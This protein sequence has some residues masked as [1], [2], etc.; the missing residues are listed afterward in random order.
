MI[1]KLCLVFVAIMALNVH[2]QEGTLS[3]YSFFGIGTLKFKGTAE[4]RA[5]GGISVYS[6]SIHVNLRNPA[7]YGGENLKLYNQEQR[8]VIFTVGASHS[9]VTL[10]TDDLKSSGGATTFDYLALSFPVGKWG[11]GIGVIPFSSVGYKLEATGMVADTML[12]TNRYSGEGGVNRA[13]LA[14]GYQVAKNIRVGID[15]NYNFGNIQ[16]SS[17]EFLYDDEGNPVQYQTRESN[18]SDLSGLNF[19][20]GV[21]YSPMITDKL[22][23]TSTFTYTPKANLSSKNQRTFATIVINEVSQQELIVNEL[24][25]D[26]AAE[27]L[28]N[29]DLTFPSE[30]TFGVGVGQPR[31]WFVGAEYTFLKTSEYSNRIFTVENQSFDDA[32]TFALGGFVIPQY[33]SFTKYW[34]RVVY[35][36]GVRFEDTGIRINNESINEFGISFG[37]GLPIGNLFSNA[38]LGFEIGKRGTTKQN[39]VQENFVNF[40][41]SLSLNDRWFQKRK[42]N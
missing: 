17:I 40:H 4:N 38:N 11:F 18:R 19:N 31:I 33:N 35:R 23:L 39:L 22:Q 21:I 10:K 6:D 15:A 13:Y 27:G 28:D 24:D 16:N 36:A 12:T 26:L 9:E 5:M 8:P 2:A 30:T 14:F 29:T 7:S 32:S 20:F 34:R 3:P 25:A 37:V 41:I 1:K 42:I